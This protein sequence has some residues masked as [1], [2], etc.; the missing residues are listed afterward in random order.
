MLCT[1]ITL[2]GPASAFFS[3]ALYQQHA[4]GFDGNHCTVMLAHEEASERDA[5]ANCL[6]RDRCQELQ[7]WGHQGSRLLLSTGAAVPDRAPPKTPSRT[8]PGT[9]PGAS[10]GASTRASTRASPALCPAATA[11]AAVGAAC[12]PPGLHPPGLR[13]LP[14]SGPQ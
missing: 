1:T 10:P 12:S 14:A 2:K 7:D 5:L 6:E 13:R 3:Y 8:P 4:G 9:S 11:T